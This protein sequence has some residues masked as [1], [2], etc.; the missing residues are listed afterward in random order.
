MVPENLAIVNSISHRSVLTL[1]TPE[2]SRYLTN[3]GACARPP[4]ILYTVRMSDF[5]WDDFQPH[6]LWVDPYI[7]SENMDIHV[8]QQLNHEIG[9]PWCEESPLEAAAVCSLLRAFLQNVDGVTLLESIPILSPYQVHCTILRCVLYVTFEDF[10]NSNLHG[11]RLLR[12]CI[13]IVSSAHGLG[14]GHIIFT[15]WRG[16]MEARLVGQDSVLDN[17]RD[18]YVMKTRAVAFWLL[19]H[20]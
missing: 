18:L 14:H 20:P 6:T 1:I 16:R 8:V 19:L 4:Q 13:W 9:A 2:S 15:F 11:R 3:P 17:L 5:R 7:H 12:N 10:N